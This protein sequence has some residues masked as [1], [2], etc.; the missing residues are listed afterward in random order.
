[1]ENVS[2]INLCDSLPTATVINLDVPVPK[3][4]LKRETNKTIE[5]TVV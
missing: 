1:M 5:L 3:A 2:E 4:L